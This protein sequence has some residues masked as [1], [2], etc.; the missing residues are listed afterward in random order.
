M[1]IYIISFSKGSGSIVFIFDGYDVCHNESEVIYNKE[2][3]KDRDTE[4]TS[5]SIFCSKGESYTIKG[6]DAKAF[7]HCL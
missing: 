3:D 2:Y 7:M 6:K 4:Y 1:M 5:N